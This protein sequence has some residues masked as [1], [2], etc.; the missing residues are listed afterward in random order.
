MSGQLKGFLRS[1]IKKLLHNQKSDLY[2]TTKLKINIILST[3]M[4]VVQ[5]HGNTYYINAHT[6]NFYDDHFE[7]LDSDG[8]S[9]DFD[10]EF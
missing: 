3:G 5:R 2:Y 4:Q 10:Y 7:A 1:L 9:V 8:E 6:V